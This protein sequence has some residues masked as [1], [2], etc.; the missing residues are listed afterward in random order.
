MLQRAAQDFHVIF[1]AKINFLKKKIK[2]VKN[3]KSA[4]EVF[5]RDFYKISVTIKF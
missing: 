1:K 3:I 2:K 4:R 5:V